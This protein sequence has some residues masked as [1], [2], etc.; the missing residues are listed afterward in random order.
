VDQP[1]G[2]GFSY[3]SSDKYVHELTDAAQQ[4]LIFLNHFYKVFPE[5]QTVDTFLTGESF[6][7]QYIPYY[8][9]AMI[10]AKF[11]VPL[12]GVAIGNG[13]MDGRRQYPSFLEYA[14]KHGLLKIDT[15][16]SLRTLRF[17]I[18]TESSF[19]HRNTLKPKRSPTVA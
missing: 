15:P 7:G 18:P 19:S 14:V 12:K 2:T 6:A 16:V 4:F 3:A 11:P 9:D 8:A 1:A 5:L 13:W 10:N 17:D